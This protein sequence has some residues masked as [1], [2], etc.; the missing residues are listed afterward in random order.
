MVDDTCL[1]CHGVQGQRQFA[2]D[3]HAETGACEKFARSSVD[4]VPH[5][6]FNPFSPLAKYG[7]LARDGVA[8]T[9][10]HRMVLGEAAA[11]THQDQPQN[12]CVVERQEALNPGLT[13]FAKTFTGSYLV[14]PPDVL[15]GPFADP[16]QRPMKEAQGNR[17]EHNASVKSSELCGSCHTVHLPVLHEGKTIG[18]VYEQTTY[19]EWAFSAYRTGTTPD[20]PLPFG[21]GALAKSCQDCH[22][23]SRD[24]KGKSFKSKIASIQEYSNFPETEFRAPSKDIDL[25]VRDGFARH[26]L[27]GL[28]YFLTSMTQQFPEVLGIRIQ[29]P[30]MVDMGVDP[31]EYTK[32]AIADQAANGTADIAVTGLKVE[33]NVLSATVK[34]VNKTGHKFPSGVSFRRAFVEFSVLDADKNVLW[35]SGRTNAAGA[36]VDGKDE[37]IAGEFWWTR[38]CASRIAPE[39][40]IHQPHYEVI[41]QQDQAQIYEELVAAPPDVAAPQCGFGVKPSGPLTTSF[42]SICAKVKDNRLLP[43]GFLELRERIEIAGKLGA[44][45]DLAEESGPFN[46]DADPDYRQGGSDSLAYRV[47]LSGLPKQAASVQA[48]LYFQ[49]T[50]PYF[51]Q[52][53]FCT[54]SSNDTKR[55][56]YLTG[57]L[58]LAGTPAQDW[59]LKLVTTGPIAVR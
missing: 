38:D 7:A 13:G 37:P 27:V 33:D 16:K 56:Y 18:R 9:A 57:K 1:G 41:E 26:M 39:A 31:A 21:P 51:L 44:G 40:R 50:P 49:A 43:H 24:A 58:D 34:I 14:G 10:C 2:I 42:L 53:R 52:D 45:K 59:K 17:P 29:D 22:M 46:V 6:E 5:P 4:A 36:I 15:F 47:P 3:R 23:P 32:R 20:G 48:T 11:K 28:N 35:A 30:M 25:P 19:P 12:R 54:S 55:L 8:C